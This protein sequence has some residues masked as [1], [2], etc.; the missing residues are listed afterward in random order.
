LGQPS[1]T[2]I[3]FA[4]LRILHL[5]RRGHY[6][7]AAAAIAPI[8]EIWS[9][10]P[11]I[12]YVLAS[13]LE[14]AE[15]LGPA[16]RAYRRAI[17]VHP[18]HGE[19]RTAHASLYDR[20]L[21]RAKT[22]ESTDPDRAA[23][24]YLELQVFGNR[25]DEI[26]LQQL[27]LQEFGQERVLGKSPAAWAAVKK[28][29]GQRRTPP[30]GLPPAESCRP[31]SVAAESVHRAAELESVQRHEEAAGL[32]RHAIVC[33]PLHEAAAEGLR[34]LRSLLLDAVS[35]STVVPG[36]GRIGFEWDA[37]RRIRRIDAG[38]GRRALLVFFGWDTLLDE[39]DGRFADHSIYWEARAWARTLLAW[40]Y[41]VDAVD[42]DAAPV[43]PE[44]P[45]DLV[46]GIDHALAQYRA[47][48]ETTP[49]KIAL[50][51]GSWPGFQNDAEGAVIEQI[52]ARRGG[53]LNRRRSNGNAE[54]AG[55]SC[56]LADVVALVGNHVTKSTFP[57]QFQAKIDL[58]FPTISQPLT[59]KRPN[60]FAPDAREFLFLSGS[61]LALKG[62]DIVLEAVTQGGCSVVHVIGPV[63]ME[64][65]FESVY[66]RELYDH[67]RVHTHGFLS[68]G[69]RVFA[70]IANRCF[71]AVLPSAVDGMSTSALTCMATGLF[72]ILSAQTGISLPEG[73]GI[74]LT[75][76]D[77]SALA[78]A[79]EQ[80]CRMRSSE[81]SR[82]IEAAQRYALS[83][84]SRDS[85]VRQ[86]HAR[87]DAWGIARASSVS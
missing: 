8:A 73:C 35:G 25:G 62:L 84:A 3:L 6:E 72:P 39:G 1:L 14:E 79:M 71:A 37:Q 4:Q 46:V 16:R 64:P 18:G 61:G 67:P 38:R 76:R 26:R 70:E 58:I 53:M 45:Y 15:R 75:S 69:S 63:A 30:V 33:D 59:I 21:A 24:L 83:H 80:A 82:Q 7:E 68:P 22:L 28:A 41:D 54:I 27:A 51:T 50:F 77:A 5:L 43:A 47:A 56:A 23:R 60:Q 55:L 29:L 17:V 86:L 57:D 31:N 87:F 9:A 52:R 48:I 40:G 42:F 13:C 34:R 11:D 66:W 49:M 10:E 44:V 81:L 74:M 19:A 32:Y 20:M 78:A 85:F 65:D 12:W 36:I 2:D